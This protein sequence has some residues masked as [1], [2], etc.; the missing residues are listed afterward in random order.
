[1]TNILGRAG[2]ETQVKHLA[3]GL[4]REGDEVTVACLR[5]AKTDIEAMR[6]DGVTVVELRANDRWT[7]PLALPKLARLAR[8]ADVVN[9]HTWD[10]TL[11]GRLAALVSRRPVVV[12]EHSGSRD[13][14][15]A[16]G[17][18]K[19]G[20]WI[21]LHNRLLDPFTYAVA[22]VARLQIPML[23]SEGVSPEKIVFVPNGVPIDALR[24]A[25]DGGPTRQ[26]LGIP[27]DATVVMQIGRL[28][29]RKN[30]RATLDLVARLRTDLGDVRAVFVGEGSA[31][32]RERIEGQAQEMGAHW[33]HFLG[34]RSDIPSIL[35]LADLVVLPS[36]R[37]AMPMALLEAM[38]VGVPQV[39][40]D[41]GDVGYVLRTTGAGISVPVDDAE[42]FFDV[43]HQVLTDDALYG[44]LAENARA[45]R[46]FD[47]ETMTRRYSC[48]F[49]AAIAGEPVSTLRL[50]SEPPR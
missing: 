42:A 15:V 11:Y 8:R 43:V 40:T 49:D 18:G 30:Q 29:P 44:R 13:F 32:N 9:A 37:E 4:A 41:V 3:R 16:R 10:A 17:G 22:A 7:R 34:G 1:M 25:S 31:H 45:S 24:A 39:A 27:R 12:T 21:A 48:L 46:H 19:R 47:A 33:A 36:L 26:E 23:T 6:R 14:Q 28:A 35:A 38:A 2:A 50:S 5:D 20:H